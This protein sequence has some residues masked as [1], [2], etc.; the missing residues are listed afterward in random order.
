ML[1]PLPM[2]YGP[3]KVKYLTH[4]SCCSGFDF[5]FIKYTGH[6]GA[7]H[8]PIYFLEQHDGVFLGDMVYLQQSMGQNSTFHGSKSSLS[9]GKG[10]RAACCSVY[11][12]VHHI[13]RL[14]FYWLTYT[15][16][17]TH[18]PHYHHWR[19]ILI[20]LAKIVITTWYYL[21]LLAIFN[22]RWTGSGKQSRR[23]QYPIL[24]L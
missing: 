21:L 16:Y 17:T 19:L 18:L 2:D 12:T 14:R 1:L 22:S 15:P 7:P 10:P 9:M 24:K 6:G 23:D 4:E 8:S 3:M 11:Y 13:D 20:K 5:P